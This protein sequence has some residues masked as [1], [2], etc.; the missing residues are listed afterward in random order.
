MDKDRIA[1]SAKQAKGSVKEAIGKV[2]SD[3]KTQAEG[4]AGKA[5][6][7]AEHGRR[8]QRCGAGCP[9]EIAAS[10]R[11]DAPEGFRSA[12]H[13]NRSGGPWMAHGRS[14]GAAL[15][16]PS[17]ANTSLRT[18]RGSRKNPTIQQRSSSDPDRRAFAMTSSRR[19]GW[20]I[21][22]SPPSWPICFPS[23]FRS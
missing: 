22:R 1:G 5:A 9:E 18:A 8:R 19:R 3:T 4:A 10:A 16:T 7:S 11:A 6:G 12:L 20:N 14:Q 13:C 2:T 21:A 17:S 15:E 23:R